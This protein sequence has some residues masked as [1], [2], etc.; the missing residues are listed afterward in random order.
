M[1]SFTTRR[2]FLRVGAVLFVVGLLFRPSPTQAGF[3][4]RVSTDGG[5][6]FGAPVDDGGTGNITVALGA[7]T[8]SA[9]ASNFI[10]PSLSSLNLNVTGV[11]A[12]ATYN[13]VV[14]ASMTNVTTAPAPQTLGFNFSGSVIPA[15]L[16]ATGHSWVSSTNTLF[17]LAGDLV[18]TANEPLP[19]SG[20]A[21]FS[22][23]V[24]YSVTERVSLTGTTAVN[25]S[26]SLANHDAITPVPAPASLILALS[27]APALGLA[28]LR[29]RKAVTKNS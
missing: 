13:L 28:W 27:G 5:S 24:P 23:T 18:N 20:T 12:A 29:R 19:T 1:A 7:L 3:Q 9:Q 17:N 15:N 14:D 4:L 8:L 10:S 26:V 16:T 25:V 6:T 2:V 22:G 21:L 11:A